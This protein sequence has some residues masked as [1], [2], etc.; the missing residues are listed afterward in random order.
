[1]CKMFKTSVSEKE[2]RF[3]DYGPKY[4]MKGPRLNLGVVVVKAGQEFKMH[5]HEHMEENFLVLDGPVDIIVEDQVM[6]CKSGDY[7]HV[8]PNE[9]HNLVNPYDTDAKLVFLLGPSTPNDKIEV[10]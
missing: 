9:K 1:M 3:G 7:V 4:L 8:E 6:N 5:Y 2:Y 10:E